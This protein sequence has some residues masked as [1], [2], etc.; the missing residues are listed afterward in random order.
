MSADD[1]ALLLEGD[2]MNVD[3]A[4]QG[5]QGI[6]DMQGIQGME[7]MEGMDGM[8]SMGGAM[9]LDEVDLFGDPVMDD[10]LAGLPPPPL[11][12]KKLQQ[13]LDELRTHGCCQGIA[14]SR[15]G[16]IASIAKDAMSID[17]RFIRCNPDTTDWE[18]SEPSSWSPPSPAASPP[19]PNPPTP[20]SLASTSAP[21]VHLAWSPTMSPDL[22]VID[23]LGRLTLLGFSIANNQPYPVR[24]WETDVVD[25]LHAVVGCY[26]LPPGMA[27]NKQYHL[28]HGPATKGQT[29]Y[30]YEHQFYPAS[31]PWHPNSSKSAFLC[32]T[33]NGALKLFFTQNNGRPEETALELESVTSSDDLITHASL[34]SDRNTL[35][36][37]LA[38]ASKQLRIVRVGIQWGLPQVDKQ[39]PPQSLP[40]R[41][42]LRESHVAVTSW[43][44]HG[45]GESALDA[46]TAQLSHIEILPAAHTAPSQPMAPPVVLTVRSYVLQDASPYHQE[47][48]SIIDRWEVVTDQPQA[49]HPAFEQLASKNGASSTPPTMT[50]LRKLDPIILPK[51]VVTVTTAQFGR[52]L[53]FA[54]SD[55]TVQYRDRFTMNE[56]YSEPDT[57]SIMHPLQVGFH[58]VN[59][60]P[61]LQV[62]FSPT[63][64]S[65][66]QICEDSAVKW[67]RLHYPMEAPGTA[68]QSADQNII[69]VALTV[70]QSATAVNQGACDD[71]LAMARPFA[72]IPDFASAWVKEMVNMLKINVDYSENSH[73]EQLVKNILLQHCLGIISHLSFRGDFKPRLH[74]GKFAM[75]ALGV[76]SVF[77]VITVANT[78]MGMKEKLNPLDDPDVVDAVTG[79]ATW[80]IS[81]LAWLTDSLFQLLDDPEIMAMLG[82]QK[83]FSD[84]AKYLESKN[85]VA[86]QLLLCSSTRGFLSALCRRLQHVETVSNR[87]AQ[88]YETRVQQ[89]QDPAAATS[90]SGRPH[91][92]L[93]RAYQRMERAVSSALVKVSEFDRLLSDLSSDIQT[94]YHTSLSPLVASK[95]KPQAANLTE[96]Q[97]QQMNDQFIKKAQTHI[98]LD[99]LV[100]QNPPPSF[101]EVLLKLFT[102]TLPA[103]RTQTDPAKLYFANYD[104][105]EVEDSPSTLA[106]R[107]AAGKYVDVFK[108]AELVVGPR[109]KQTNGMGPA[110]GVVAN[111]E[112]TRSAAGNGV[113][114]DSGM[115][116]YRTAIFGTWTGI[117][118]GNGPQWRRC[119][120]CAAVVG[121]IWTGKPGYHFV[122]SQQRKCVCGGSWGTVPR[123]A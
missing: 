55:G 8:G 112:E 9:A 105:L 31:G 123:G 122:L 38:T 69:R 111:G 7:G 39:V 90:A 56:M 21:F 116:S 14:W 15:Q 1:M 88:Y 93:S 73:H 27:P 110:K 32:V 46:S 53:C 47:S 52:V 74:G 72:Q 78:P 36:I 30:R 61:C 84:L 97:K 33:T 49:L 5:L 86:L 23:A 41:P 68:L 101:R 10:A 100:G 35:L 80:G 11:P 119:V 118:D 75:L 120:R 121:D 42:S 79:C 43:V 25:D 63:N 83:R 94:A 48:Q 67:N 87:A 18:L 106:T 45:S 70:A 104:L 59:N 60:T 82:E 107:K 50:R 6:Q 34:C 81:L 57:D 16:T 66:A 103:F 114:E 24:R 102:A 62:A 54:F 85:H 37:A 29:E 40:L 4:M 26:W 117:G 3:G 65:F 22:A 28:I 51:V 19:A 91:P 58:Y 2:P 12:S 115:A 96:Q 113:G 64:C 109:G 76:R 44:Q 20:I 17:L 13:R 89:Q 98:E 77:L 108:R 99:M 92:A 71:I 95:V